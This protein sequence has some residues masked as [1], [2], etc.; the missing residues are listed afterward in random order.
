M[1]K[2]I[3]ELEIK[4]ESKE[5]KG[6]GKLEGLMKEDKKGNEMEGRLKVIKKIIE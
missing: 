5:K 4:L 2:R 1:K 3:K 6:S